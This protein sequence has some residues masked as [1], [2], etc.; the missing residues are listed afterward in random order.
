LSHRE[1]PREVGGIYPSQ[2]YVAVEPKKR[3]ELTPEQREAGQTWVYPSRA[4][5][6]YA[7]RGETPTTTVLLSPETYR[8]W[9]PIMGPERPYVIGT[10]AP[11]ITD[12]TLIK[13]PPSVRRDIY[14]QLYEEKYVKPALKRRERLA[15][16]RES[17]YQVQLK[18]YGIELGLAKQK[19]IQEQRALG[20]EFIGMEDAQ[21]LFAPIQRKGLAQT[22]LDFVMPG[23]KEYEAQIAGLPER[24]ILS[25]PK[26]SPTR[27]L[28]RIAAPFEATFYGIG[29]LVGGVKKTVETRK[30]QLAYGWEWAGLKTPIMP[31]TISGA[32]FSEEQRKEVKAWT[33]EE[34]MAGLLGEI[35]VTWL[36]GKVVEKTIITP[37][38]KLWKG[39]K[40][41]LWA[42]KHSER[43]A[44]HIAKDLA[45]QAVSYP[46]PG[47]VS[48]KG[49]EAQRLAWELSLTPRT[50]L[51]TVTKVGAKRSVFTF[52]RGL[53]Y[54]PMSVTLAKAM[55]VKEMGGRQAIIQIEKRL[56]KMPYLPKVDYGVPKVSSML[57]GL[58]G[59]GL[60][61]GARAIPK[62]KAEPFTFEIPS[63]TI[64]APTR[65]KPFISPIESIVSIEKVI[66]T[67]K[68]A[69]ETVQ[70]QQTIVK[71]IVGTRTVMKMP[72]ITVPKS[73]IPKFPFPKFPEE[74]KRKKKKRKGE[75]LLDIW[76]FKKHPISPSKVLGL[77]GKTRRRRK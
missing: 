18:L 27:I 11:R 54:T 34:K 66:V 23:Q 8:T 64:K 25:F 49:L 20:F 33:Q 4:E 41:E 57:P 53:G 60:T 19:I 16:I 31:A 75:P 46:T 71:Q 63:M 35:G 39:S 26:A 43:Y 5:S 29:G 28:G 56:K 48:M 69:Q 58:F 51:V 22:L 65:L 9:L 73:Q 38:S 45:P 55:S 61:V 68:T 3:V 15:T 24:G 32:I 37:I 2:Q 70:I 30:P 12:V 47:I 77:P 6:R 50:S 67:Q 1:E 36:T 59:V 72:T 7:I 14:R 44:K 40:P 13:T 76:F 74:R 62:R 17:L 52:T 42:I 10:H 21:M